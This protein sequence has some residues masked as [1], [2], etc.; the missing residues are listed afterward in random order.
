MIYFFEQNTLESDHKKAL[1]ALKL[2]EDRRKPFRKPKMLKSS[3][4]K[5]KFRKAILFTKGFRKLFCKYKSFESFSMIRS[6]LKV[7]EEDH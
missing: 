6:L 5:R 1:K 2:L 7:L 4:M 3:F